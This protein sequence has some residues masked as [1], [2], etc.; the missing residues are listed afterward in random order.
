MSPT[1]MR[2][3]EWCGTSSTGDHCR[4]PGQACTTPSPL[5][6][7]GVE[8]LHRGHWQGNIYRQGADC[9]E[10][11]GVPP[12]RVGL[13]E[14]RPAKSHHRKPSL[15]SGYLREQSS[16]FSTRILSRGVF[17]HNQPTAASRTPVECC[18]CSG[19]V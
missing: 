18:G 12:E 5:N 10:K 3:S 2:S 4:H 14:H 9:V 13:I 17:Q 1:R 15:L 6:S 19:P 16:R 8:I 11:V 7:R